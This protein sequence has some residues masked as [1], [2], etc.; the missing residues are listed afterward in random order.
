M[1]A[2]GNDFSSS[3][4]EKGRNLFYQNELKEKIQNEMKELQMKLKEG[5]NIHLNVN[6]TFLLNSSSIVFSI[7]KLPIDSFLNKTLSDQ[8]VSFPSEL[9]L[10]SNQSQSLRVRFSV[11]EKNQN[12]FPFLKFTMERLPLHLSDQIQTNLSRMISLSILD[13]NGNSIDVKT[14]R[15]NPFI[16]FIPHDRSIQH[17][18][19][20]LQNVTM[21]TNL[22][23][24]NYHFLSLI[25]K[26]NQ[27]IHLEFESLNET[28]S[29]LFVYRF[30]FLP[31]YNRSHQLID[32]SFLFCSTINSST[33]KF[34]LDN[35]QTFGHR[36]IF[37]G[38]GELNNSEVKQFCLS[39]QSNVTYFRDNEQRNFTSNY[40]VRLF[41]SGCFYFDDDQNRW[42]S[43]GLRVS[44]S[45]MNR[46]QKYHSDCRLDH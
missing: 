34:Y 18:S 15:N 14:S 4:I 16:I 36:S 13:S 9:N 32:G 37:F 40:F 2:D 1:F 28:L 25:S 29:Y 6:Q 39:N 33:Y 11:S 35:E 38:I 46:I 41:Q 24:F 3:T 22:S 23:L 31:I 10:S 17:P 45:R 5:L 7:T 20:S 42:K 43:D 8:P 30:D 27:S 19:M 12:R 21:M 44:L 26:Q